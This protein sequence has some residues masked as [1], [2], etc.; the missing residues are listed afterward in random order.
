MHHRADV[1]DKKYFVLPLSEDSKE[2]ELFSFSH[3]L[4]PFEM[5]CWVFL[6]LEAEGC[7]VLGSYLMGFE[8]KCQTLKGVVLKLPE[9]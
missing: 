4:T 8:L 5:F 6:V 2:G 9:S 7:L 1:N 3:L